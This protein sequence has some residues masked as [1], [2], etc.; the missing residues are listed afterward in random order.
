MENDL[1]GK[2]ALEFFL[3][4]AK[5][6]DEERAKRLAD[7]KAVTSRHIPVTARLKASQYRLTVAALL[8]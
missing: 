2:D 1:T 8:R 6:H 5:Q 4:Q 3:R 7:A